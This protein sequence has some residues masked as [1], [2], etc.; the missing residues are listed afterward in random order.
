MKKIIG[1]L[2]IMVVASLLMSCAHSHPKTSDFIGQEWKCLFCPEPRTLDADQR[3][4]KCHRT[5][6][7]YL[8]EIAKL[9]PDTAP[10]PPGWIVLK[11]N[12]KGIPPKAGVVGVISVLMAI[13]PWLFL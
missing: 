5:H 4:P 7:E 8:A 13:L 2:V 3:C 11:K 6:G 9:V 12:Q 10:P 1:I